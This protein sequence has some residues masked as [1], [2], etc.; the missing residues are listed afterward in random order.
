MPHKA[1]AACRHHIPRAKR[2]VTNWA[3]YDAALRQRGSL[4]VW[5]SEEAIAGWK[6]LP[7]TTRG[8]QPLFSNMAIQT[9]LILRTVFGLAL[10]QTEGLIGSIIHLLGIELAVPDHSTLG[11]RAQTVTLPKWT[12]RHAG[13]L[14]LI[15]DS[16]GLKLNGP[17]EWLVEKHGTTKRR[18]WHKLH[19]GLDAVSG[20]I[21]AST[22]TGRDID[23]GSQVAALLDQVD[24]SVGVFM[25][26]GAYDSAD[27]Y[28]AV[29][30]RHPDDLAIVPP[31]AG[32][33]A[34]SQTSPTQRD[35]HIR[36]IAARGRRGWQAASG[37]NR[38]ALV[39][40]QIGRYKRV[41]GNALRSHTEEADRRAIA[42]Y[43]GL[44]GSPDESGSKRREKGLAKSGNARLRR[45]LIQ[46]AW[47]FLR[48]QKDSSLAQWYRARTEI[49]RKTT[50]IVALAR[51]LLIALWRMVTTGEIPTGI[52]LWEAA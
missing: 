33:V 21:V 17:G 39:E 32:A 19:I 9:G 34:S 52:I 44:T 3:E 35:G 1:N 28:A 46:L 49:A 25:G 41:I 6:A 22:L 48:F 5:F 37:Y 23:D 4:T 38:R 29:E 18:S 11:R 36:N 30:E 47:R 24:G 40:A 10:R 7:R 13:P 12:R 26:D 14:Q 16:T 2:R 27:V 43:A 45:S 15:V 50:M 8:G 31:R 51:K 20:E 42:R